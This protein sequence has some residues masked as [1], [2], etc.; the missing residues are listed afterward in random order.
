MKL[1]F[2]AFFLFPIALLSQSKS[3][4]VNRALSDSLVL[5]NKR[6]ET[7]ESAVFNS[8]LYPADNF[9]NKKF[10]IEINPGLLLFRT[11]S[12][13]VQFFSTDRT[14][15]I[16]IPIY[17]YN[18]SVG[19]KSNNYSLFS[20]REIKS[21]IDL[22]FQYRKFLNNVQNGSWA[23]LGIKYTRIE[24]DSENYYFD[25]LSNIRNYFGVVFSVGY[26]AYSQKGF[27]YGIS[28]TTGRYFPFV[29]DDKRTGDFILDLE[30][31]KLGYAF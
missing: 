22:D 17:Y 2:Y 6:I 15:E 14:A 28:F 4:D 13:G 23:G 19:E 20:G 3:D 7:L 26:R 21:V 18:K 31:L 8:V 1:F 12:G 25:D 10:G 30:L 29:T 24:L 16:S 9:K 5:L 11:I 27:Y